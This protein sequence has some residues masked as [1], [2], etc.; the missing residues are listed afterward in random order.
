MDI[1]SLLQYTFSKVIETFSHNWF[2]LVISILI[3]AALKLYIDQDAIARF[4]RRNTRNS[5]L[6]STGVAVATPLCSCGTTAIV[7]GMMASTVPWAPIVAF[8][9]SSPLTSPQE[10]FYSAGLF[11]WDFAIAF[12]VASIV[13]GLMGGAIASFAESRGWLANQARMAPPKAPSLSLGIMAGPAPIGLPVMAQ[14]MVEPVK[15]AITLQ[16]FAQE[17]WSVSKRLLPL[18]VGFTFIGYLLNGLIPAAWIASLFGAGHAYSIPLAATLGLPFYINTE[19]SLPLVR[20]MLDSGM[21]QGAA[22]AFLITGAGTSLG[23]LGGALTIARWRV[24]AIVVGTLWAGS[25]LL[26]FAYNLFVL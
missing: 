2:L 18:F 5:V 1:I 16:M 7:L 9:V 17:V 21:S 8:L 20:A 24:I 11:G 14:L 23:A 6:M 19:A 13:L 4:L 25:M 22:L 15:P 3:S 10:L 12:F 26:G